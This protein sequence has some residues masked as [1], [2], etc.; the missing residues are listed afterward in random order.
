MKCQFCSNPATVHLTDI[1]HKQKREMHLC[2][3]CAREK[4]LIPDA[5]QELNVPAV[6]QLV[7]GSLPAPA[8]S[9]AADAVCPECGTPYAHFK[10]QGRLGCPHD[11]EAFRPLL[12]PLVERVQNNAVRHTGKV[13]R[14]HRRRMLRARRVELEAQL[15]SAVAGERYEEAARLRDS[16]RALGADHES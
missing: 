3:S 13:P 6:L 4:N 7:L 11:Y 10:A 8:R 5:P 16:I 2:D 1:V 14:R 9:P 15:R 12:E